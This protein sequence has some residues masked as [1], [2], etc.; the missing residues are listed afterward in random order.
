[1]LT[2]FLETSR[3]QYEAGYEP[4]SKKAQ[5]TTDEAKVL[6]STQPAL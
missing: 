3:L 4:P 2:E 1:M 6:W 5:K